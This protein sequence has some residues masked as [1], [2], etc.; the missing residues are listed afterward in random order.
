MHKFKVGERVLL[1]PVS[2]RDPRFVVPEDDR[3]LEELS[4]DPHNVTYWLAGLSV[5][6][7]TECFRPNPVYILECWGHESYVYAGGPTSE[8][9]IYFR[10]AMATDPW[11]GNGSFNGTWIIPETALMPIEHATQTRRLTVRK[12]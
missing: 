2:I 11:Q 4:E 6:W 1:R 5:D 9:T 12:S 8:Y 3:L 10:P 7:E